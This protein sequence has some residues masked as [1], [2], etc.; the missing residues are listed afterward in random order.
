MTWVR[1]AGLIAGLVVGL[2][3]CGSNGKS[4]SPVLSQ[5]TALSAG[6]EYTCGLLAGGTVRCWGA[7]FAGQLG[8]PTT[9]SSLDR[10]T[11]IAVPG[12]V[13]AVGVSAG[14]SQACAVLSGGTVKCWGKNVAPFS[15]LDEPPLPPQEIIGV[16]DARAVSVGRGIACALIGDGTVQCWGADGTSSLGNA[17]QGASSPPDSGSPV[18]VSGVGT[19]IAIASS[20]DHN[21]ALLA[22]GT[23]ECW[24]DTW[25][26]A[27]YTET[28][29][30]PRVV[31]V[32]NSS[33]IATAFQYSCVVLADTTVRCWGVN[34]LGTLGDG[35]TSNSAVPVAVAGVVG[36][37]AVSAGEFHAC[38]LLDGG[39][40]KCW[41][42]NSAGELGDGT[43][44][45]SAVPV[46]VAGMRG[47]VAVAAGDAHTCALLADSTVRCWGAGAAS[48]TSDPCMDSV[49]P[50]IVRATP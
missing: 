25:L 10:T 37:K 27:R 19:A 32:G 15:L 50:V 20:T 6:S 18:S 22:D 42:A 49:V 4:E 17:N 1:T 43:L 48:C 26:D 28:A 39:E 23:V 13:D 31:G 34:A 40:L 11:A 5:V 30:T 16:L 2:P 21:C 36:A 8:S 41:G 29:V 33:A 35:S 44:G 46:A 14:F 24:G 47:A 12:V 45:D 38:T 7:N 9:D 3:A